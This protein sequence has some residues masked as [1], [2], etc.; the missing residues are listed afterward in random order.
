MILMFDNSG[1][2]VVEWRLGK[3]FNFPKGVDAVDIT[4]IC[5]E[6]AELEFLTSMI[7]G[8]VYPKN[9]GAVW[10]Y[11]GVAKSVASI[12]DASENLQ[13]DSDSFLQR[14]K[15]IDSA[16]RTVSSAIDKIRD[17]KPAN[18]LD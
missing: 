14:K 2:R 10:W 17:F 1:N 4:A 16:K 3:R 9:Y 7:E 8:L 13:K 12:L 15:K 6:G 18:Y 11:A 5:A